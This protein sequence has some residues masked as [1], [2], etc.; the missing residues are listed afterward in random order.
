MPL[1]CDEIR[2]AARVKSS[3]T[4]TVVR[5]GWKG[6]HGMVWHGIWVWVLFGIGGRDQKQLAMILWGL[7]L[8][9]G[10][11]QVCR[12][13]RGGSVVCVKRLRWTLLVEDSDLLD[14]SNQRCFYRPWEI[15][16]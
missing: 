9:T 16:F 7:F 2:Y 3:S 1:V 12:G 11:L 5:R 14:K 4:A 8:S 10:T 13:V 15:H 6:W